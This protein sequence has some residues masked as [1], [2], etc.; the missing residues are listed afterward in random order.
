MS[1]NIWLP[2]KF[3]HS[4]L[5]C[6]T[7]PYNFQRVPL[8]HLVH[9]CRSFYGDPYISTMLNDLLPNTSRD[10]IAKAQQMHIHDTPSAALLKYSIN[11]LLDPVSLYNRLE[12]L[13][14][15]HFSSHSDFCSE[16]FL[17]PVDI[18]YIYELGHTIGWHTNNHLPLS[19][20]SETELLSD[21]SLG[22]SLLDHLGVLSSRDFHLSYPYGRRDA[23]PFDFLH[24]ISL[25][26]VSFAWTLGNFL[27]D[28]CSF[29]QFASPSYN[30]Q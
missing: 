20:L 27:S 6:S 11:F 8:V 24:S 10:L 16:Y 21:I 25:S 3:K 30:P 28:Q 9:W 7:L 19:Q 22:H 17:S 1:L 18:Q 29:P 15:E 23:I 12:Q 14:L 26:P 2:R 13:M 4:S 5:L